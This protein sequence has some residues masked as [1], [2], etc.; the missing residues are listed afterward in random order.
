MMNMIKAKLAP[1]VTLPELPYKM[2]ELAPIISQ[3]QFE[4]HYRNH[5]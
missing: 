5:H 2:N 1:L 4:D 3:T